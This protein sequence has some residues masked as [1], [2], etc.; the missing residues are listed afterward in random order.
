MP[1]PRGKITIQTIAMPAHTNANGD[2]FGGWLVSQMD[3]AGAVIA[4]QRCKG[5]VATV[6]IDAMVFHQPVLVGDLVACYAELQNVGRTSMS[7]KVEAWA[8]K[9]LTE[10]CQQVTEGLFTYVA[11]DDGGRPTPVDA[12]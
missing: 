7:V 11:I 4:Q 10:V 12:P 1:K 5:R 2:M 9:R 3:L 8:T 6:A